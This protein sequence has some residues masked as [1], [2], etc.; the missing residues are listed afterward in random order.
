M[1]LLTIKYPSGLEVSL[2]AFLLKVT[3]LD[4]GQARRRSITRESSGDKDAETPSINHQKEER[5]ERRSFQG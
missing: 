5:H 4:T 3:S 1:K 2:A